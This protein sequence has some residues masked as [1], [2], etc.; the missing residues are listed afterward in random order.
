MGIKPREWNEGGG[1]ARVQTTIHQQG[2]RPSEDASHGGPRRLSGRVRALLTEAAVEAA[3]G[4]GRAAPGGPARRLPPHSR[5]GW[6]HWHRER[7]R[8]PYEAGWGFGQCGVSPCWRSKRPPTARPTPAVEATGRRSAVP[9]RRH[10]WVVVAAQWVRGGVV[11]ERCSRPVRGAGQVE[12]TRRNERCH[13]I[14]KEDK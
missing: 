14:P 7:P 6:E 2:H 8:A 12:A 5:C 11:R 3:H 4:R 1:A 9:R 13:A 10:C